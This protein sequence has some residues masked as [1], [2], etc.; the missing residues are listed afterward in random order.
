MYLIKTLSI[1]LLLVTTLSG[2]SDNHEP[3]NCPPECPDGMT[4]SSIEETDRYMMGEWRL[5]T[6][7]ISVDNATELQGTITINNKV[8]AGLYSGVIKGEARFMQFDGVGFD[9]KA[10]HLLD[11]ISCYD[12]ESIA[13][14]DWKVTLGMSSDGIELVLSFPDQ[15]RSIYMDVEESHFERSLGVKFSTGEETYLMGKIINGKSALDAM[16]TRV[17]KMN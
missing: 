17:I 15:N 2:C 3:A 9:C 13:R 10:P 4:T 8:S 1:S 6:R 12:D 16:D 11:L 14:M 7:Q 5:F